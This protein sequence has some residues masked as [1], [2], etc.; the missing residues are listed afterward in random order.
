MSKLNVSG[1]GPELKIQTGTVPSASA[2]GTI[3]GTGV[4]RLGFSSCVLDAG[5]GASTGTPT[6]FTLDVKLQHSDASGS[7]YTDLTGAAVAQITAINTRKRKTIDLKG[8]KRYI[9]AVA[10]TAFVGGTTPTLA[11]KS[12]IVLGGADS[13]PAQ[14]DD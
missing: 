11:Q 13:V 10:V 12:D 5:S 9:R 4:D 1:I 3:N 6:S 7:G 2:A 8:A 14:A